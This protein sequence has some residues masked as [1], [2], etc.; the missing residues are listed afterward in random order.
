MRSAPTVT[1]YNPYDGS[2]NEM[3]NYD[4]T[5]GDNSGS[6]ISRIGEEGYTAY[7][8]STSLGDF[9][10]WHFTADAEL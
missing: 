3:S 1:H 9:I 10:A 2:I 4:G 6:N 7:T 8:N 5:A